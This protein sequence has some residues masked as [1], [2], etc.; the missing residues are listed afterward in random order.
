MDILKLNSFKPL[1]EPLNCGKFTI[2]GIFPY[3]T[4]SIKDAVRMPRCVASNIESLV[5]RNFIDNKIVVICQDNEHFGTSNFAVSLKDFNCS[6]GS[7]KD[8]IGYGGKELK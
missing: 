4:A 1:P 3:E 8:V 5:P 2:L 7:W 6:F